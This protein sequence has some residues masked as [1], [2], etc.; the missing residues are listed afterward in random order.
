M[1]DTDELGHIH[2]DE[3]NDTSVL[4][5]KTRCH[6]L[7]EIEATTEVGSGAAFSR[8]ILPPSPS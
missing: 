6:S 8:A 3:V 7:F 2:A 4:S 5:A 1:C